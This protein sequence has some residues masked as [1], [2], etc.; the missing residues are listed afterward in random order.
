MTYDLLDAKLDDDDVYAY[1][2]IVEREKCEVEIIQNEKYS[3]VLVNANSFSN[4]FI[5]NL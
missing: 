3:L 4:I 2:E 1:N 5:F